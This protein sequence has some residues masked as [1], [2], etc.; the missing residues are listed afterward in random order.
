MAKALFNQL[1][2]AF[3]SLKHFFNSSRSPKM[4]ITSNRFCLNVQSWNA[5][6]YAKNYKLRTGLLEIQLP[7]NNNIKKTMQSRCDN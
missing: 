7:Q 2:S 3:E 6:H 4:I 5:D 1:F